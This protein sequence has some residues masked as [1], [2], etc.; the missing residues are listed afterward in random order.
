MRT[1]AEIA[2]AFADR[3]VLTGA[4]RIFLVGIGGAGMSG[5]AR[6]ARWEHGLHVAGTDSARSPETDRLEAEG[7]PVHLG[8]SGDALEEFAIGR[9]VLVVSDAIDLNVSPEVTRAR[10][11]NVPIV[12]RSALLGWLV[13]DRRVVAVTGTHGKTTTTGMVGTALAA[14]GFDPLV[15]VG[16]SVPEFGG[17]IRAGRGEWAVVEACEAYDGFHDLDPTVVIL[18]NLEPDHLDFHGDWDG[19]K[20]SVDRFVA[21]LPAD[22]V[23]LFCADDEGARDVAARSDRPSFGYGPVERPLHLPGRHN[24]TNAGAAMA[25]VASLGGDAEKALDA[26]AAFRG[27]ERRLQTLRDGEIAVIDDYAHHP[28]EIR[29]T[30]QALRERHPDRRLVV[31]FQPHLYSRTA[32]HLEEFAAA[33]SLADFVVLTDIYPAREAPIPGISSARIAARLTVPHRYVP[34]RDLLPRE[35]KKLARAGD[36]V[37]GMG[38]G[39]I[40]EFGPA[41]VAELDRPASKKVVVLYGGDN[42]ERE[43][44]ILSGRAVHAALL[45]RG[46]E[47]RLVDLTTAFL[48]TG[49]LSALTGENRPD[50]VFLA[51]HGPRQE[52]GAIQG[53][54]ELMH[55]PYTG[56][57]LRASAIAMDKDAAKAT[58]AAAGLPVPRGQR[59]RTGDAAVWEGPC[60]V[61]PNAGG[62]T[63][64][65]SFVERAEDL[66]PAIAL[67]LMYGDECLVEERLVG[68]EITVP[69]LVDRTLPTILIKPA[70]GV[71]DFAMKYTPG[72]TEEIVPAPLDPAIYAESQRLAEA[73]HRALGCEGATRTDMIVTDRGPVILEVN[74]LPG[75]TGTSLLPTAA[76]AA[77][78]PFGELCERILRDAAERHA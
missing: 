16:A 70:T 37:V 72:A 19:L 28:T 68:E 62:S 4:E 20:G 15:V 49:D 21:T 3:S 50:V 75:M 76:A 51:G 74:T 39:T 25:T 7:F 69:Y 71:Y 73:A 67:A 13:K 2:T 29:V 17:P 11:L 38:A 10:A 22:G 59:V 35:V 23:L 14:T 6:L 30:L 55:L 26:L 52:D 48:R 77:G 8:H 34:A 33:L 63:V 65:L 46:W 57:G 54:L 9:T 60:V 42:S 66:A 27:S 44:S 58:L 78:I 1:P 12:R 53:L 43:V 31:V 64:G 61:K 41:F 18:T 47:S 36:L 32:D 5:L 45:E 40:S 56:S 24:A